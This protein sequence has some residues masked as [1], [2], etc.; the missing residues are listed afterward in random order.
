MTKGARYAVTLSSSL[1]SIL[2]GALVAGAWTGDA[3]KKSSTIV[4]LAFLGLGI[5]IAL[6][7]QGGRS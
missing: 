2:G 1:C 3:P 4:G 5:G 7:Q 6:Q